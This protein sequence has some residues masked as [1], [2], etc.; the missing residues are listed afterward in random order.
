LFYDRFNCSRLPHDGL[1]GSPPAL[2]WYRGIPGHNYVK[3]YS[4]AGRVAYTDACGLGGGSGLEITVDRSRLFEYQSQLGPHWEATR[5]LYM[6]LRL[7]LSGLQMAEG[8][9][10][11]L[12]RQKHDTRQ[13]SQ[14]VL[15][16]LSVQFKGGSVSLKYGDVPSGQSTSWRTVP[17]SRPFRVETWW[18]AASNLVSLWIDGVRT[19][20]TVDLSGRAPLNRNDLT[21][22]GLDAG[23]SGKL[24]VDDLVLDDAIAGS[25][26]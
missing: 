13:G 14:T 25:G 16:R 15:A 4:G 6:S 10:F 3:A 1:S 24:C 23:T 8:D 5:S 26:P 17:R 19:N 9:Q 11:F 2:E 22:S 7:D 21:L 18:D 20:K 12:V